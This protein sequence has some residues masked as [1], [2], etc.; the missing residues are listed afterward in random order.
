MDHFD[1]MDPFDAARPHG[2]SQRHV[3][4]HPP[5]SKV[6]DE[7]EEPSVSQRRRSRFDLAG[8]EERT[9]C[10][11]SGGG[12]ARSTVSSPCLVLVLHHKYDQ[13]LE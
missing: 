4:K 3:T 5:T 13:N 12:G 6:E 2:T 1:E 11:A 9:S 7:A 10:F 8:H